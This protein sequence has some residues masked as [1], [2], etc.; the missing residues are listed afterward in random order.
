MGQLSL[1]T[2]AL[3]KSKAFDRVDHFSLLHL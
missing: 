1:Y 2:C 3:D